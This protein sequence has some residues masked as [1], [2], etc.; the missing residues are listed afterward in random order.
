[1]K[2]PGDDKKMRSYVWIKGRID[3]MGLVLLLESPF[4]NADANPDSAPIFYFKLVEVC[5]LRL[6]R[7]SSK[8]PS[9]H[10]P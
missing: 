1:M 3:L 4:V 5:G 10:D 6:E 2:I 9:G 8:V 7:N